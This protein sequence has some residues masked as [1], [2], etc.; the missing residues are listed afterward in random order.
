MCWSAESAGSNPSL[1]LT[2]NRSF[3]IKLNSHLLS[4][5]FGEPVMQD[6]TYTYLITCKMSILQLSWVTKFWNLT[7]HS[8]HIALWFLRRKR[9]TGKR[10]QSKGPSSPILCLQCL[11]GSGYWGKGER[12]KNSLSLGIF[13]QVPALRSIWISSIRVCIWAIEFSCHW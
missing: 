13:S 9:K 1:S 5:S 10:N 8:L 6:I 11:V 4:T 12:E 7:H 2:L 3:I